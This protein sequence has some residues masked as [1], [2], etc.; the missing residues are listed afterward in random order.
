MM[1]LFFLKHQQDEI[2]V[3][4]NTQKQETENTLHYDY[5]WCLKSTRNSLVLWM[6]RTS[7]LQAIISDQANHSGVIWELNSVKLT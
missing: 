6:L 2:I 4:V 3:D 7:S 1:L 5:G